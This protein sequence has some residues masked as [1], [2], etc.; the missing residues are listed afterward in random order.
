MRDD[1][2]NIDENLPKQNDDDHSTNSFLKIGSI[3]TLDSSNIK[4]DF[5]SP[6][7][8][9]KETQLK[10]EKTKD[11]NPKKLTDTPHPKGEKSKSNSILTIIIFI[12]IFVI[13]ILAYFIYINFSN[14][15]TNSV[16]NNTVTQEP[17]K[18][19]EPIKEEAIKPVIKNETKEQYNSG[20]KNK[21]GRVVNDKYVGGSLIQF[22]K[23]ANSEGDYEYLKDQFY[24]ILDTMYVTEDKITYYYLTD[25]IFTLSNKADTNMVMQEDFTVKGKKLY[26]TVSF[27]KD[28]ATNTP[29]WVKFEIFEREFKDGLALRTAHVSCAINGV[30][31][32]DWDAV[33]AIFE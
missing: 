33:Y 16:T 29:S 12:L 19:V 3:K 4:V 8:T 13:L 5:G 17:I 20:Y 6:K 1:L 22:I 26:Y 21:F 15:N 23:N 31:Y 14:K 25:I 9:E 2:D 24:Q 7:E 28:Y 30:E 10:S 11:P 32:K 18:K 27:P